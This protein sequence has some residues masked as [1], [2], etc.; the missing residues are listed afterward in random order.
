MSRRTKSPGKLPKAK[1]RLLTRAA[2]G[3]LGAAVE[4]ACHHQLP[5]AESFVEPECLPAPPD[6]QARRT[7]C[8]L[9][10]AVR[11]AP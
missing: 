9:Q 5:L 7:S 1:P 8:D 6:V 10:S 4:A 2:S 11:S 3:V